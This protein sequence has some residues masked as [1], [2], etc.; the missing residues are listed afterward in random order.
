MW[1]LGNKLQWSF[2]RSVYIFLQ[3]KRFQYV[4][5]GKVFSGGGVC[6]TAISMLSSYNASHNTHTSCFEL[7]KLHDDVIKWK[8]LPRYRP[9]VRGIQRSAV[10]SH[11][12]ASDAEL[13]CIDLRLKV[14]LNKQYRRR[15]SDTPPLSLWR[16]CNDS[17]TFLVTEDSSKLLAYY[18]AYNIVCPVSIKFPWNIW[19]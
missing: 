9:F 7:V 15:W 1:T 13:W 19:L 4:V 18:F 14:R 8:H 10:N 2:D 6:S 5:V 11:T 16:H 3:E 12:K 17:D